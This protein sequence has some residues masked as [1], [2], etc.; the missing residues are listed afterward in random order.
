VKAK[1][2]QSGRRVKKRQKREGGESETG[3]EGEGKKS[4][5]RGAPG[6]KGE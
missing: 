2:E 6:V 5:K 4:G 1:R 3:A